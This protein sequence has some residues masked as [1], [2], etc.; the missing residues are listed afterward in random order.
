MQHEE[1]V[2]VRMRV[3]TRST[4]DLECAQSH[5]M[6]PETGAVTRTQPK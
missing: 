5:V 4:P 6:S 2:C 3:C 1:L